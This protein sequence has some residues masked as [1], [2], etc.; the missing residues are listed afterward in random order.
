MA[1]ASNSK[2]PA[3]SQWTI[4]V[5]MAAGQSH[6]L[7]TVAVRDL[8]EMERGVRG[9][10]NVNVVVQINRHWPQSAQRYHIKDPLIGSKL[11]A[12]LEGPTNM[13]NKETLTAF[14]TWVAGNSDFAADHFCLVLW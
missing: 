9:K 5:Y 2:A 7:D 12:Q 4:M 11:L 14:L 3:K 13:G 6:E 10:D 1:K 8:K